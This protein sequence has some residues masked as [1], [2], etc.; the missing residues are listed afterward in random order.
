MA[1]VYGDAGQS[2]LP[3]ADQRKPFRYTSETVK[4]KAPLLGDLLTLCASFG[5]GL[6]QVLY[7]RHAALLP[8]QEFELGASYVPLPDS[9]GLPVGE[10]G[11]NGKEVDDDLAYP[12]PCGLYPNLHACGI[13]LMT[14]VSFW[15]MLPIL[16]YS[17][18]ERFRLPDSPT[19]VLSIAGMAGSGLV[20]NAGLLVPS[21]LLF[22]TQVDRL[23]A[24][25][26]SIG[27]LGARRCLCR[28]PPH[29][30]SRPP[31][32]H[33]DGARRR[34]DHALELGRLRWDH[35]SIRH[36]GLRYGT[37]FTISHLMYTYNFVHA[38]H[39]SHTFTQ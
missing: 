3:E 6:Y 35:S 30:R 18:Y 19:V 27:H 15:I 29:D 12:P 8:D 23:F 10:L 21:I 25:L 39:K 26:D 7:K 20:F 13:G 37:A 9:D 17:G 11:E 28:Q 33:L 31:I 22:C 32:R 1:V 2:E 14:R 34:G 38:V 16:H 5:Y 4:P 24:L 36:L